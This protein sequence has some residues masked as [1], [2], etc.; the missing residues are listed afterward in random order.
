[1]PSISKTNNLN[2]AIINIRRSQ[3]PLQIY[4]EIEVQM[5][6]WDISANLTADFD[7]ASLQLKKEDKDRGNQN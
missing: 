5:Y 1:M 4:P 6:W 7:T 3:V 2:F